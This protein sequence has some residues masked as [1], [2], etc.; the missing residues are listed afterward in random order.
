MLIDVHQHVWTEP[1]VDELCARARWPFIHRHDGLTVLHIAGEQPYVLDLEGETACRRAALLAEDGLDAVL[2][3]LSSPV[4]IESLP[5]AQ[6]VPLLEAYVA[7]AL[8]LAEPFGVWGAFALDAIDPGDVDRLLDRGCVGVSVPAG[9]V[10]SVD[11]LAALRPALARLQARDAPLFVH[12]GPAPWSP[13]AESRLSDPLWWPALT[14]Y[15]ADMQAAWCAFRCAGRREHPRLRV[16]FALLAGLA[17][18]HEERLRSRGGG[19]SAPDP[20]L[21]YDTSSYGERAIAAM[22]EAVGAGQLVYGSDRPVLDAP[23]PAGALRA[24]LA[25]NA[26]RLLARTNGRAGGPRDWTT[27]PMRTG[28][29]AAILSS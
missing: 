24:E 19:P 27:R 28:G 2:V 17:P 3:C 8:A 25:A 11:G 23:E 26:G 13:R 14:E 1:L 4:G 29:D 5:R 15:V 7:G 18:L 9:A 22:A 21:F 10:A 16:V 6:A 20:L 12:P